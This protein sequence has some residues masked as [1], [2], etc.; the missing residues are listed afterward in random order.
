MGLK[1]LEGRGFTSDDQAGREPV[2]VI[3]QNLAHRLWPNGSAL[4]QRIRTGPAEDGNPWQKVV[5]VVRDIRKTYS[6]SLYPDIYLPL[7]QAPRG[8]TALLIRTAGD[9]RALEQQ[10]RSTV[11]T[12]SPRLALSD[13]ES[14][15][16]LLADRRG[17]N[18]ILA[19][20][21]SSVAMACFGL[22]IVGLYAVVSYLVRLRRKEFAIRAT[23]GA[24]GPK[25][26]REVLAEA[27]GMLGLGIVTGLLGATAVNGLMRHQMG[28]L[29]PFEVSTALGVCGVV[30]RVA[31]IALVIPARAAARVD[32]T[33][34]LRE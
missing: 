33:A 27:R 25:L 13:V 11:A 21:V 5:G 19:T 3:S 29:V 22:T 7:E 12:E 8:Y 2:A 34:S 20:F 26:G 14:M 18:T 10:I 23:L 28:N 4:G 15:T 1:I 31:L 32:L 6:D 30:L 17:R 16:E 24:T 9:P